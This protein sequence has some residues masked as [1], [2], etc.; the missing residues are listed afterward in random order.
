[1]YGAVWC[2]HCQTEKASFGSSFQY[3]PYVECPESPNL[4]L[5]K[6]IEGYPTWVDENGVKYVGEQGLEK[7]SQISG[8]ELP[9]N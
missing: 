7:L 6:G 4:C 2:S 3:V 9:A 1:M 5:E 8:C